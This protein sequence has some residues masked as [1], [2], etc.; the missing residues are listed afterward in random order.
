MCREINRPGRD[1]EELHKNL[2]FDRNKVEYLM[3]IV[4]MFFGSGHDRNLR[5][6]S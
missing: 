2:S 1:L 3:D 6:R 4:F 5:G